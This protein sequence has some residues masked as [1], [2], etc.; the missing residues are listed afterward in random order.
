MGRLNN[1]KTLIL[2]WLLYHANKSKHYKFYP[3]KNRIL[4]KYGR[5]T[6]TVVQFIEGKKCFSCGATGNHTYYDWN[7]LAYDHAPCWNCNGTGWYKRPRWNWLDIVQFGKYSFHQPFATTYEAPTENVQQFEG[8]VEHANTKYTEFALFLIFLL[9]E[10]G[11]LKRWW[12]N[13]RHGWRLQSWLPRNWAINAIHIIKHGRN[14]YPFR[15]RVKTNN[16][17]DDLPF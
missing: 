1:M 13:H 6:D 17:T 2:S 7:G 3:I 14:A 8:Y 16:C 4:A 5:K 9:Y 11:F 10:P 12:N 15:K